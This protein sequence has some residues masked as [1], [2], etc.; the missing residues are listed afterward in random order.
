[1]AGYRLSML[2]GKKS[3]RVNNMPSDAAWLCMKWAVVKFGFLEK[4]SS[5]LKTM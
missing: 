1:M 2:L 4:K 5:K 3:H